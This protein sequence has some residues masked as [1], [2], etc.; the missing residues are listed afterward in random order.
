[1]YKYVVEYIVCEIDGTWYDHTQELEF[2]HALDI[3][4]LT[5]LL[6]LLRSAF[7]IPGTFS[8]IGIGR[9]VL[10]DTPFYAI[11]DALYRFGEEIDYQLNDTPLDHDPEARAQWELDKEA[12][13]RA[14]AALDVLENKVV[15][16]STNIS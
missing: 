14:I 7:E 9:L 3:T 12:Q 8:Y 13:E 16:V 2:D 10:Q 4:D 15:Y 5:T 11:R 1:M 6:P